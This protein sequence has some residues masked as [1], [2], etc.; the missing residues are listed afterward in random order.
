MDHTFKICISKNKNVF[1]RH[2]NSKPTHGNRK[3]GKQIGNQITRKKQK[4]NK[5]STVVV[6]VQI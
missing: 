4:Q 5:V 2:T 3:Q 6:V 1:I